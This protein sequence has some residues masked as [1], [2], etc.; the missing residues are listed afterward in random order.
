[1][2]TS[3]SVLNSVPPQSFQAAAGAG[4]ATET[5]TGI[6]AAKLVELGSRKLEDYWGK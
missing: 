1:M 5:V 6:G 3:E 2:N 4:G